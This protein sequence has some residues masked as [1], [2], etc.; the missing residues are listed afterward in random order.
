MKLETHTEK[1]DDKVSP[2]ANEASIV[3]V[4]LEVEKTTHIDKVT[5][6]RL[7]GNQL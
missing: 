3:K 7:S 4:A 1:R 5:R 2:I 6:N